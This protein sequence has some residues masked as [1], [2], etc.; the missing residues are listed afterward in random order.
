MNIPGLHML[1]KFERQTIPCMLENSFRNYAGRPALS[2]IDSTPFTYSDIKEKIF[3]ISITLHDIG[4]KKGDKVAVLGENHPNWGIAFFAITSYGATAVPVMHEFTSSE[5]ENIL[6]HSEAKAIFISSKMLSKLSD[7]NITKLNLTRILLD[8]FSVYNSRDK[9]HI[10][11]GICETLARNSSEY[12]YQQAFKIVNEDDLASIIY[13][14]GTTGNS[15][16]VMLTHKNIISNVI[17]IDNVAGVTPEDKLLSILPL[18]HATENTLGLHIPI[19]KGASIYYLNKPPAAA[20]LLPVLEKIKPTIMLSVPLIIEKIY[21]TR[22]IPT[23]QNNKILKAL[24][25]IPFFRKKINMKAGKKLLSTFGG[26]LRMFC[27]GGAALAE[28]VEFFLNEAEFPYTVGYGLTET[29]PMI[30]AS[31]P[32]EFKYQ[33]TGK[34]LEVVEVKI[35]GSDSQHNTGEILVKGPNVM[36]GYYKDPVKTNEVFT[37]DGWLKTGDLGCIDTEGYLY[38]KGRVKNVII[39]PNGKN[40]YPEELEALINECEYV[41]DSLVMNNENRIIAKI[42]LDYEELKNNFTHFKIL[43]SEINKEINSIL[44]SIRLRVNKRVASFSRISI[45]Y[46]QPVPFEKTPTRKIKRFL[47]S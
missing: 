37:N 9:T 42:H 47:Y 35:D 21:R 17:A 12:F 20:T 4:I 13:T 5:V 1:N 18:S 34:I 41:V 11:E 36:K 8:D 30:T 27:I 44:E 31:L 28:D 15:K 2:V 40:I 16:G 26:S 25:T 14:S 22:I 6:I 32:A 38:I 19:M 29:S 33:S 43:E 23:I 10:E 39:G 45:V 7:S 46:E 3:Q 24:Y